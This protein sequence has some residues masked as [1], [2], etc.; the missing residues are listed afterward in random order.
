MPKMREETRAKK[1]G[2]RMGREDRFEVTIP[3]VN[4]MICVG[5]G[6]G[7][8]GD[9]SD[10]SRRKTTDGSTHEEVAVHSSLH[11]DCRVC[12]LARRPWTRPLHLPHEQ[13]HQ[14]QLHHAHQA[15]IPRRP[16][17]QAGG[18]ERLGFPTDYEAAVFGVE[19]IADSRW[20]EGGDRRACRVEEGG[21][22][23]GVESR[24]ERGRQGREGAVEGKDA[25]RRGRIG[26]CNTA[27]S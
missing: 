25:V 5:S 24:R 23:F 1:A 22:G 17:P 2:T 20:W 27:M 12:N 10:S 4:W 3:T 9:V 8:G 18:G 15:R 6:G 19:G 26:H 14:R 16:I 7:S 21:V 13:Q 11:G